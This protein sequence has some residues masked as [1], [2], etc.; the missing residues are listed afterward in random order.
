MLHVAATP[1]AAQLPALQ[2]SP[3]GQPAAPKTSVHAVVLVPGA[4]TSQPLLA[5]APGATNAPAI[6]QP[7]AQLPALQT[8]PAAQLAAPVTSVHSVVLVPGAH[9]SQPLLAVPPEPTKPPAIQQ[10]EVQLA[11]VPWHT[12][13]A[14]QFAL[15]PCAL[16]HADVLVPG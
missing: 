15:M 1:Q 9:T 13:P 16:V 3:V 11:G 8:S 14:G 7:G 2:T 12:S 6:E 5:V 4:H 10:P